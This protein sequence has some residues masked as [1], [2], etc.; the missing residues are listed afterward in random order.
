MAIEDSNTPVS[1]NW[2]RENIA[3]LAG[4]IEG[5]GCFYVQPNKHGSS[6][7][8][9]SMTDEDVILK[10]RKIS[11]C[12]KVHGPSNHIPGN[13]PVWTWTVAKASH[14]FALSFAI[15]P[16]LCKRRSEKLI[17]L[18]DRIKRM[19]KPICGRRHGTRSMYVTGCRCVGCQSAAA[20][21]RKARGH[22]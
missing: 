22:R 3:W 1:A 17:T 10:A 21:Y 12:G 15:F 4:L 18:I 2:S 7:I 19:T 9:V 16:F 20:V 13:K 8:K 5:E 14:V 6:I 11:G